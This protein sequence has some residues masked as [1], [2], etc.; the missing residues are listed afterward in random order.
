M[1]P[2]LPRA[3]HSC[4]HVVSSACRYL[5]RRL[6][7]QMASYMGCS[8]ARSWIAWK[9][10]TSVPSGT[11]APYWLQMV[12]SR[13]RGNPHMYRLAAAKAIVGTDRLA[14]GISFRGAAPRTNGSTAQSQVAA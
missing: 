2:R 3:S 14:R 9:T 11:S 6:R 8:S 4:R 7:A 1:Y 5:L 12:V 13:C 10:P